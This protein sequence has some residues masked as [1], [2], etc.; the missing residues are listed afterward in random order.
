MNNREL[1]Y[2]DA[3]AEATIQAMDADPNVFVFGLGVDDSKG[4]FGTT[5]AVYKKFGAS[6]V[7]ATPAS[8]NALT[9]ICIGAALNGKRPIMVHARNDFM[10]LTLDQMLNNAAKWK[11][12]YAGKS[13]VPFITRGIIG[14]GWGQGP[15]HF[16]SIQSIFAHF[17]GLYVAMPSTPYLA[18]GLI[19]E[20]VKLSVPVVILEH[21]ALFTTKEIVPE[22]PYRYPFGKAKV[23]RT[24]KDITVVATSLMAFEAIK[25][26]DILRKKGI[27]IEV[28]DPVSLQPLDKKT[29]ISSIRKTGRLIVAD[30]GWSSCG[31]S[32]E[33]AA[34]AS[35]EAFE[36]LKAPI[37]RITWPACP[38]PVSKVLED[39]FYP[40]YHDIIKSVEALLEI[41][42]KINTEEF[43][44]A[45]VFTGPY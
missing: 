18:K 16:Q 27:E 37:K 35:D 34:V 11:F 15:T 9:G 36:Y 43:R 30:T 21:R 8:E 19:L 33:V 38:C 3:I 2:S 12:V 45:D 5:V 26:A 25:A 39:E 44:Q 14:K 17:P 40:D 22:E 4:L 31:F 7:I 29:I 32:A 28:V 23:L 1:T 24:G 42:L 41:D 10:F 13:S 20:S 6:R